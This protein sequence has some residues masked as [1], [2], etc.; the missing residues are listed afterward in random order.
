MQ[1]LQ[2]KLKEVFIS[3]VHLPFQDDDALDLTFEIIRDYKPSLVWLGGDIIDGYALSSWL[4]SSQINL[5]EEIFAAESFFER[6][7]KICPNAEIVWQ[8]G[9]HEVRFLRYILKKASKLEDLILLKRGLSIEDIFLTE[10]FKIK[11]VDGPALIGK[12]YHLHGHE[13]RNYGNI[14]HVALNMLR[15]LHKSVIFGHF[16]VLQRFPIKEV[17]ATYKEAYANPSLIDIKKMPYEGYLSVDSFMRG[18]SLVNYY[19]NDLF[20]VQQLLF[21]ERNNKYLLNYNNEMIMWERKRVNSSIKYTKK[22]AL[23]IN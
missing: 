18:F 11:I 22:T 8:M 1:R 10:K 2:V 13:K 4:T 19:E 9:N 5:K 7:R 14:V 16:H 3:D 20:H 17:D 15:W 6:L 23:K 21:L 12:L